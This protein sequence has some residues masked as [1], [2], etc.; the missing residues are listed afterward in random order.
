MMD[1]KMVE[2]WKSE[3]GKLALG[4]PFDETE[5]KSSDRIK[6]ESRSRASVQEKTTSVE[7][8]REIDEV[9]IVGDLVERGSDELV[10]EDVCQVKEGEGRSVD[11]GKDLKEQFGWE[12]REGSESRSHDGCVGYVEEGRRKGGV[13]VG[14][15]FSAYLRNLRSQTI[16]DQ[17]ALKMLSTILKL[18]NSL[19]S[20]TR[21]A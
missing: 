15:R 3:R 18:F 17:K 2:T 14:A 21:A 16:L 9:V 5:V 13:D 1:D 8:R 6:S 10:E 11:I 4:D 7:S 19:R 12:A 20:P